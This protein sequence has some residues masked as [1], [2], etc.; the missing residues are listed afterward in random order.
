MPS[1]TNRGLSPGRRLGAH[2]ILI[3]AGAVVSVPVL[4]L[5][6]TASCAIAVST[7]TNNESSIV[8]LFISNLSF[9]RG[10]GRHQPRISNRLLADYL[11]NDGEEE[12]VTF[13]FSYD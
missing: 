1:T 10:A 5:P 4:K 8:F 7:K 12:Y 2:R 9:K 3:A 6:A 11:Y 13:C